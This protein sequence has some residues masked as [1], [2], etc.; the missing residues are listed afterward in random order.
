MYGTAIAT[1]G[2][3]NGYLLRTLFINH[4]GIRN[5]NIHS[6]CCKFIGSPSILNVWPLQ[7][8]VNNDLLLHLPQVQ[9]LRAHS[10]H[11]KPISNLKSRVSNCSQSYFIFTC[12]YIFVFWHID[13]FS[14]LSRLCFQFL[15]VHLVHSLLA[16][17]F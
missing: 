3:Y 1:S 11:L 12:H 10:T 8:Q 7:L 16:W 9:W 2:R 15:C 6:F 5:W 4:E 17:T 14:C 13:I